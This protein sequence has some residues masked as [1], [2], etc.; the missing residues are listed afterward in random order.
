LIDESDDSGT[1]ATVNYRS[2]IVV[3]WPS[4]IALV[5]GR[6]YNTLAI[7]QYRYATTIQLIRYQY[8]F[9]IVPVY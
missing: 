6:D 2:V 3:F 4:D 8:T 7:L 5:S 9:S 1:G